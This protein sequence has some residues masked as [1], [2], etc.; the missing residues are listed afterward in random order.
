MIASLDNT[1]MLDA[2]LV[3]ILKSTFDYGKLENS[4]NLQGIQTSECV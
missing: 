1:V 2:E 3:T 4:T